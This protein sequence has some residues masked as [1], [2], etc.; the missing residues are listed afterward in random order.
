MEHDTSFD[1]FETWAPSRKKKLKVQK[2][3][4]MNYSY[5]TGMGGL[6]YKIV[7]KIIIQVKG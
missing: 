4:I 5:F 6:I 2:C 7:F 1:I 3:V